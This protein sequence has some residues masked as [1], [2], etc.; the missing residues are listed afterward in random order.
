M[1]LSGSHVAPVP[2]RSSR[3]S[4][5]Y[6]AA[7]QWPATHVFRGRRLRAIPRSSGRI[8]VAGTGANL[9]LLPDA[10]PR[11]HRACPLNYGTSLLNPPNLPPCPTPQTPVIIH[12]ALCIV[13]LPTPPRPR[14]LCL[15]THETRCAQDAL[16]QLNPPRPSR[17]TPRNPPPTTHSLHSRSK[18]APL[19]IY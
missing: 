14:A 15:Y 9:V 1:P 16:H 18:T 7:R 12:A 11:A 8:R 13:V 3:R 5:P 6:N 17:P 2:R 19:S 4:A 10:Q